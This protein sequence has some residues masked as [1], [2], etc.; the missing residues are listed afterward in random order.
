MYSN[1]SRHLYPHNFMH[2]NQMNSSILNE[3]DDSEYNNN[4][5]VGKERPFNIHDP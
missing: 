2:Y 3:E 4:Q 5:R 1:Y